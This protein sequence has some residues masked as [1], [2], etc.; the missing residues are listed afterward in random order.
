MWKT[1]R[2]AVV[3]SWAV[4]AALA[5]GNHDHGHAHPA[6]ATPVVEELPARIV[7]DGTVLR[8][9]WLFPDADSEVP[10]VILV[11]GTLSQTRDG[12]FAGG[13]PAGA[14]R[15]ALGRMARQ[16]AAAW[17]C[18]RCAG[19]NA[20]MARRTP[21]PVRPR[22]RLSVTMSWRPFPPPALTPDHP[23]HRGRRKCRWV[24][25]VSRRRARC[26]RRRVRL[27]GMPGQYE[28]A[29]V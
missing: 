12:G 8:G 5:D 14:Q 13:G 28:Q 1:L 23:C 18:R 27:S 17:L 11:G 16:L 20:V 22:T 4:H 29:P 26:P 9:S 3:F 2:A 7:S 25:R 6:P 15:D 10:C 24:L 19:T 21:P